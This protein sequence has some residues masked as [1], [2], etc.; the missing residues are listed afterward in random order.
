MRGEVEVDR[1]LAK[2]KQEVLVM[3]SLKAPAFEQEEDKRPPVDLCCIIDRSGS[4]E[5]PKLDA[6]KKAMEFVLDNLRAEDKLSVVLYDTKVDTLFDFT[7]MND[8]EKKKAWGQIEKVHSRDM[9][10]LSGGLFRGMELAEKRSK[11]NDVCSLLLFT[12]GLA[13]EGMTQTS[14]IT[15]HLEKLLSHH[16]KKPTVFTFG[17]GADHNSEMLK[18]I[19]E[20]GGGMFY[21]VENTDQIPL[22]FADCLGG[23]NSTVGQNLTLTVKGL[24]G[25]KI[26]KS[27]SAKYKVTGSLPGKEATLALGDIYSEESRDILF[28]ALLPE[29]SPQ[30]S[31]E[32]I[33]FSLT[34]YNVVLLAEETAECIV[35]VA[36]PEVASKEAIIINVELDKQRNRL[37]VIEAMKESRAIADAGDLDKA[38]KNL[39]DTITNIGTSASGQDPFCQS[40]LKE[41][42]QC[43][44]DMRDRSHYSSEG[45]KKMS[46]KEQSH[47]NQR[48]NK[49]DESEVSFYE[50]SS[51]VAYKSRASSA[52]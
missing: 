28:M 47:V 39:D 10:N 38:K 51:K 27:L 14:E 31:Q 52:R 1:V 22:S 46:R 17:F 30:E 48:S 20:T 16:K 34:Y 3:A 18:A 2:S 15:N 44:D 42:S 26:V 45:S 35:R 24:N 23:L 7:N 9:T 8:K 6:V 50:T 13:N 29:V 36:R 11:P 19:S 43:K 41:L 49:L 5:G 33:H 4:M 32:I 37:R 40:L 12:D 21:F 25:V